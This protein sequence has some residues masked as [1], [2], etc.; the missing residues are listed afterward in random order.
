MRV[1]YPP[2]PSIPLAGILRHIV[3]EW[4]AYCMDSSRNRAVSH[5]VLKYSLFA[6][7]AMSSGAT[8]LPQ[9]QVTCL[10]QAFVP[11]RQ[12][13]ARSSKTICRGIRVHQENPSFTFLYFFILFLKKVIK[14]N[15]K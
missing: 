10:D 8:R 4:H 2:C 12:R 1:I 11:F 3:N 5:Q 7:L 9:P 13:G 15:K 6:K 14:S